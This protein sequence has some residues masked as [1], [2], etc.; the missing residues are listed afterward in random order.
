MEMFQNQELVWIT[1]MNEAY[2]EYTKNFLESMKRAS[3]SFILIVYYVDESVYK[4]LL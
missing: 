2:I 1:L 3:C 4:E